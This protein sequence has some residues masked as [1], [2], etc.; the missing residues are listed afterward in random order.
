M[1]KV[2]TSGDENKFHMVSILTHW[3][4]SADYIKNMENELIQL[5]AK[6]NALEMMKRNDL[7]TGAGD[8]CRKG[9]A[10][11]NK[12]AANDNPMVLRHI[13]E[14]NSSIGKVLSLISVLFTN[15]I[16]YLK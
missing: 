15:Q 4:L 12:L 1:V 13:E 14:L 5:K 16:V 7:D 10:K 11:D 2:N 9:V 6:Y 8:G 3:F